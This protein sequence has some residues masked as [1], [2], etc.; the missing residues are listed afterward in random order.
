M[1]EAKFKVGQRANE[2][3]QCGLVKI[4]KYLGFYDNQHHYRVRQFAYPHKIIDTDEIH[5]SKPVG[6]T[7]DPVCLRS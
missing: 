6:K 1:I 5:L 3:E 4:V 7:H 2:V